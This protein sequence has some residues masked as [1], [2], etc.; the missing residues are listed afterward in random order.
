[1][2]FGIAV[3]AMVAL[4]ALASAGWLAT[5]G[6]ADFPAPTPTLDFQASSRG[7]ATGD[8]N[9][10]ARDDILFAGIE[11]LGVFLNSPGSAPVQLES[12][13]LSGLGPLDLA[14]GDL[15]RDGDLDAVVGGE[16]TEF[17]SEG[18]REPL[19]Y[20]QGNPGG[21]FEAVSDAF[22]MLGSPVTVRAI[23]VA[24]VAGSA[25]P[26]VI[27]ARSLGVR[28]YAFDDPVADPFD[29]IAAPLGNVDARSVAAG[30]LGGDGHLD[31]AIVEGGRL[32]TMLGGPALG[33]AV[34][35]ALPAGPTATVVR[36]AD[37]AGDAR[38]D[39]VVLRPAAPA[40]IQILPAGGPPLP[41]IAT[42]AASHL[43][44]IGDVDGDGRND[45]VAG[46][47]DMSCADVAT[48]PNDRSLRI[49]FGLRTH[50]QFSVPT[51][52]PLVQ[53]PEADG[54]KLTVGDIAL[55]ELE[56]AAAGRE[57]VVANDFDEA[58]HTYYRGASAKPSEPDTGV[59]GS[60]GSGTSGGATGG[61]SGSA[62][63]T[64]G[65]SG[66]SPLA[67]AG[68]RVT[69]TGTAAADRLRGTAGADVIAGLSGADLITG[70]GGN[71]LICGG[72][73]DDRLFGGPGRDRLAGESGHD[74]LGGGG[75]RDVAL[76]GP[77]A[78]A[79]NGGGGRDVAAGGG[80]RDA[81]VAEVRRACEA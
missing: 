20:L 18:D 12:P 49:L 31:I 15:D 69:L 6:R 28:I 19:R 81:C 73:G 50:G 37:V 56:P 62:G 35:I 4:A 14:L 23:A 59:S 34:A 9:G 51:P 13:A 75:G 58:R 76:G 54:V 63:G 65:G 29:Q 44:E 41:P 45:L 36:I 46:A 38:P 21:G 64:S 67:C 77:G 68:R 60:G 1:M 16:T 32:W 7:V 43:L 17:A 79:I 8:L 70:L 80:G 61:G 24:D 10:D 53:E 39:L 42:G 11:Q 2:R 71:D 66:G 74:R 27:T 5:P 3:V 25:A 55:G 26:E 47:H 78:D 33:P 40:Q 72:P 48:C 57:I 30:Q 22:G 52:L